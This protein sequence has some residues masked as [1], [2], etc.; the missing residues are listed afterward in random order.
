MADFFGRPLGMQDASFELSVPVR[1]M[2]PRQARE[3]KGCSV[4][5]LQLL[6]FSCLSRTA[7]LPQ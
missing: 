3:F 6:A 2:D 1:R 7:L 5:N 4:F